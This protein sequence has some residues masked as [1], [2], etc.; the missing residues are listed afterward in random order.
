M[1]NFLYSLENLINDNILGWPRRWV[2]KNI[3]PWLRLLIIAGVLLFSAILAFSGS[4][5]LLQLML[6]LPIGL[7][8]ILL[9]LRWPP[10]GLLALIGTIMIPF[11]GPSNANATWALAGLLMGLWIFDMMVH[12]RQIR[13]PSSLPILP[14]LFLVIVAILAFGI[15]QMPWYTFAQPAPL[16]AQLGGLSLFI[17]SAGVFLLAA[18]YIRDVRW[19]EWLCWLLLTTGAV[20]ILGRLILPVGRLTVLLFPSDG[21]ATGSLFW[22][23]LVAIS[24][25]Q[26]MFNK[27]LH[28][29]WRVAL[30]VLCLSTL[31]VAMWQGWAWN[32]GWVPPLAA[33]LGI[34]W[35][36]APR[37]GVV[38][39][40]FGLAGGLTK[41]QKLSDMVMVGDNSYSLGTRTDAWLIVWEIVKVNP[42]LG[43]GPANYY[44]YTP[45]FPIRCW[46]VQFNSHSQYVDLVAQTGLLGLACFLWFFGAVAWLGWQLRTRVPEGFPRAYVYAA[47]GGVVGT[48]TAAFFGDWVIPF[49]YNINLGGFRTSMLSWLFLGGL[50]ALE[51]IYCKCTPASQGTP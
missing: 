27:K 45:L 4:A 29:G 13:L 31:Y 1:I 47:F 37:L 21:G 6:V 9:L 16:G 30:G 35:A 22:T 49:F 10:L 32:S 20:Y 46:A 12:R 19:L 11:I 24:F 14:L 18:Y 28:S 33:V 48:F 38:A 3:Q 36:G 42:I 25:S 34:L 40:L 23:W 50:V 17:L 15:G 43:L 5:R 2:G 41:F 26:V 8:A 44:W 39:T 7:G 51:Q